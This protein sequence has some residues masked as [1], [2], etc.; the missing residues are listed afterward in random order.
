MPWRLA[1]RVT[2]SLLILAGTVWTGLAILD[3]LFPGEP[4]DP[5]TYYTDWGATTVTALYRASA[6]SSPGSACCWSRIR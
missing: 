2:G 6:K 4:S 5:P 1:V 3:D